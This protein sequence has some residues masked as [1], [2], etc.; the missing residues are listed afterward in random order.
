MCGS[1][2]TE[3]PLH[4]SQG[5]FQTVYSRAKILNHL[6]NTCV[7]FK[8]RTQLACGP[9]FAVLGADR[10]ALLATFDQTT[11]LADALS[12]AF[13]AVVLLSIVSALLL[14]RFAG[15]RFCPTVFTN[16]LESIMLA[17]CRSLA[18]FAVPSDAIMM[19]DARALALLTFV[20]VAIMLA[21]ARSAA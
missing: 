4:R 7:L 13:F 16:S 2:L 14:A 17:D 11:M 6:G 9:D 21:D 3:L 8:R 10:L 5:C 12:F 19:A 20:P 1:L 18:G 15:P